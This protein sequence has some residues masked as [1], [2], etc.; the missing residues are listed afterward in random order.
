VSPDRFGSSSLGASVSRLSPT[1]A[2]PWSPP[3]ASA[4]RSTSTSG[5]AMP[6][7]SP[8]GSLNSGYR[9]RYDQA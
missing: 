9:A 7:R 8:Q 1:S 5:F 4:P 3:S 6:L 2:G